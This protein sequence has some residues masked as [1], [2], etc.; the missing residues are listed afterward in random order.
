MSSDR[1]QL[2]LDTFGKA[3]ASL[4]EI[5][6]MEDTSSVIRD[7]AIKRFEYCFDLSWKTI[8]R[9][10]EA[11]AAGP[12]VSPREAFKAGCLLGW[13]ADQQVWLDMIS[14]RNLTTHTYSEETAEAVFSRLTIY[15][16]RLQLLHGTLARKMLP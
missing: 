10:A 7:A 13:I 6:A 2:Q 1:R 11:E 8:K 5:M 15:L 14:D 4:A 12:C 3:L 16:E 9:F